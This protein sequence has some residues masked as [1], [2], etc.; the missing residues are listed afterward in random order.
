MIGIFGTRTLMGDLRAHS[1]MVAKFAKKAE[2]SLRKNELRIRV[3][4]TVRAF[5]S[6]TIR[7]VTVVL[8]AYSTVRWSSRRVATYP[9]MFVR[10]LVYRY[11]SPSLRTVW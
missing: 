1:W 6:G 3:L 9:A 7:L 8:V 10:R 2:E 4:T 5:S 11:D